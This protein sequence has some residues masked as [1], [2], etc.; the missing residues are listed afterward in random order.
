MLEFL[1]SIVTQSREEELKKQAK[2]FTKDR[3]SLPKQPKTEKLIE[4]ACKLFQ[5]GSDN[6]LIAKKADHSPNLLPSRRKK[7][8]TQAVIKL[9][10]TAWG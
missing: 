2:M 8:D 10:T 7:K 5:E 9:F 1:E 4:T 3:K 6:T